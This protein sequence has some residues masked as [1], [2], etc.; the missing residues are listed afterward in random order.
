MFANG[1]N[2]YGLLLM[3]EP[4][5]LVTSKEE[6]GLIQGLSLGRIS[7]KQEEKVVFN[8][9]A[10]TC[11]NG[12]A[13]PMST[14]KKAEDLT[15]EEWADIN[16]G[17]KIYDLIHNLEDMLRCNRSERKQL[18]RF[19]DACYDVLDEASF[20]VYLEAEAS[21]DFKNFE[22]RKRATRFAMFEKMGEIIDQQL[23][24]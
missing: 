19:V 11:G 9:K 17:W 6:G 13:E 14:G 15:A 21:K 2:R 22:K 8:A 1:N 12:Q 7:M 10:S 5:A 4:Q 18:L 24:D 20:K 16:F 3:R 23:H